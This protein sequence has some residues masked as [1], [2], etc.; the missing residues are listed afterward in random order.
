[1]FKRMYYVLPDV[2]HATHM[3][4]DLLLAQV[5]ARH[6]H[7]IAKEGT[8]I[9]DMPEAGLNQRTDVL[10]GATQGIIYGGLTGAA[11]G[12]YLYQFPPEGMAISMVAIL[13]L[14]VLGASFGTWAASLIGLDVPNTQLER[15]QADIESGKVLMMIDV[16]RNDMEKIKTII[17]RQDPDAVANGVEP[18]LPAFP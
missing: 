18:T 4:H 14:G 10:H 2:S 12:W 17:S 1:M 15:F 9:G 11:L 3:F 8:D 5:E 16:Q 6:I 7:V 13:L